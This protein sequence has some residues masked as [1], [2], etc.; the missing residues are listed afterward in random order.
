VGYIQLVELTVLYQQLPL[1]VND[2]A[3]L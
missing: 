3:V 2:H 1:V